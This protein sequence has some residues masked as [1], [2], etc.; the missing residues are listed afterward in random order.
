[1]SVRP[2]PGAARTPFGN[3][4]PVR[5]GRADQ[6]EVRHGAP[7][8]GG[9]RS[10]EV[11]GEPP[12]RPDDV[13]DDG[14][15]GDPGVDGPEP[16]ILADVAA[17]T[18]ERDEYL[19]D[20]QRLKAEFDNYRKRV[21]RLQDE[22]AARGARDLA[23]KL[24]EVLD[25]LDLAEAH[26]GGQDDADSAEGR[27]LGQVRSQ[28]LDVLAKE[29]LERVDEA[30]VPFDPTVHDAVAHAPG[31]GQGEVT[32][33]EVMRAGYRWHGSVLRPAMVRVRG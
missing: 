8:N 33:E 24:L 26:L 32:V 15:A 30:D 22:Q 6:P 7:G 12:P 23:T 11:P 17:L 27:A 1:M 18:A 20:V 2:E 31:D 29:G 3:R 21:Q 5:P 14:A 10:P 9:D 28:L 4:G 19:A 25:N 16:K 13:G